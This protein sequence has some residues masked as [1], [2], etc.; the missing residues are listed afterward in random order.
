MSEYSDFADLVHSNIIENYQDLN[1]EGREVYLSWLNSYWQGFTFGWSRLTYLMFFT[2]V[3]TG[4][5]H[6]L[7]AIYPVQEKPTGTAS[8]SVEIGY[9][10]LRG[11]QIVREAYLSI[12]EEPARLF[13]GQ[14]DAAK[15]MRD[16]AEDP[17]T[18]REGFF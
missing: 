1:T 16:T 6:K 10:F 9:E 13:F 15:F 14:Y 12:C 5:D 2:T 17:D 3:R 4:T 7:K 18:R 11:T 8:W